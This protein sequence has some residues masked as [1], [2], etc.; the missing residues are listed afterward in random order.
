MNRIQPLHIFWFALITGLVIRL[1]IVFQPDTSLLTRWGSDDLYYYSQIAGHVANG[2]GFTFDGIHGTNGFQPLFLF[3]LIPFGSWMLNDWYSSW[4]V[5]SLVVTAF[6]ILTCFQLRKWVQ[7]FGGSEWFGVLLPSVFI[8]HPKILSVTL[9]GTEAAL[10]FLMLTLSLRA[11]LWMKEQRKF[12]QSAFV[13]SLFV[14][15]RMEFSLI[16]FAIAVLGLV[17]G[18]SLKRW[19]LV[20]IAPI[21]TFASWLVINYISSGSVMPSSGQAKSI[22]ADWYDFS[23]F[24][25]LKGAIGTVFYAESALSWAVVGLT[26][27]GLFILIL[28]RKKSLLSLLLCLGIVSMGLLFITI[29]TLHGFRDWYLIPQYFILI[30]VIA[31][32]LEWLISERRTYLIFIAGFFAILWGEASWAPRKF[33]G[34]LIVQSCEEICEMVP[35]GSRIGAYNAGLT[36]ACLGARYDVVNLDGVVNNSILPYL[37]ERQLGLYVRYSEIDF[38]FDNE[39]SLLFFD[40]EAN[41]YGGLGEMWPLSKS[42]SF[43][44]SN[45]EI[46]LKKV[47]PPHH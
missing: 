40:E 46:K 37:K 42:E 14:L 34:Q 15:T 32:G 47:Y 41:R 4:V 24:D 9:N 33:N 7:E 16:L 17:Q 2:D 18:Q 26:V 23:F 29:K 13:F 35:K 6:S 39:R 38:L 21:V 3:A 27:V 36:G 43:D 5:V 30:S 1:V 44:Y 28:K 19:F 31:I 25:G 8:L 10:S 45:G 11:F 12:W 22:H 20:A